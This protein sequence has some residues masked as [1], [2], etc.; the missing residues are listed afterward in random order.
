MIAQFLGR[1]FTEPKSHVYFDVPEDCLAAP[2]FIKTMRKQGVSLDLKTR[3][4][5]DN[6][7]VFLNGEICFDYSAANAV[8]GRNGNAAGTTSAAGD[9]YAAWQNLSNARTL[10]PERLSSL[11]PAAFENFYKAYCDGYLHLN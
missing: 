2:E 3:L 7:Y 11:T 8:G 6:Q 1:Y 9:E 4:L 5:Y 10:A